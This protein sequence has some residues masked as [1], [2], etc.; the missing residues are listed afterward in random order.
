MDAPASVVPAPPPPPPPPPPEPP[1]PTTTDAAL[2]AS[3]KDLFKRGTEHEANDELVEALQCYREG[4]HQLNAVHAR[5]TNEA[6]RQAFQKRIMEFGTRAKAIKD[7]LAAAEAAA[8]AAAATKPNETHDAEPAKPAAS[9]SNSSSSSTQ[10][11]DAVA[12]ARAT[13]VERTALKVEFSDLIG[14]DEPIR[15]VLQALKMPEKFPEKYKNGLGPQW[16]GILL[17]GPPGTGKTQ[18]AK[19][20][21]NELGCTFYDVTC[22]DLSSKWV[23]DPEKFVKA[24]FEAARESAPSIIFMDEFDGIAADRGADG[25]S[26]SSRRIKNELW[27]QWDGLKGDPTK[28]VFVMGATNHPEKLD[29]AALRRIGV[30]AHIGLPNV[31]ARERLVRLFA[32]DVDPGTAA[33]LARGSQNYSG[34]DL[35]RVVISARSLAQRRAEDS[36]WMAP[37]GDDQWEA[38]G[39]PP[40]CTICAA[41]PPLPS[42]SLLENIR[43][44]VNERIA[45]RPL[46]CTACGWMHAT[47]FDFLDVEVRPFTPTRED[48]MGALARMPPTATPSILAALEDFAIKSRETPNGQ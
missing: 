34:D 44:D 1:R 30:R 21:A 28:L 25:E 9:K 48:F 24:L 5:S 13:R 42:R 31:D 14:M 19:A 33:I 2:V 4:C 20:C 29:P 47:I 23:G 32:A 40:D 43:S 6:S 37:Y 12:A 41:R 39:A 10:M 38:M 3:A 7:A 16:K 45:Q 17:Y 36:E 8:A 11:H 15:I 22:A 35:R 27:I 46:P 18:F 26:D